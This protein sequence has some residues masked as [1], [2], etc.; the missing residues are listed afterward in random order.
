MFNTLSLRLKFK[1]RSRENLPI[2]HKTHMQNANLLK[3]FKKGA[4]IKHMW[5]TNSES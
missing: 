3:K 5:E 4:K 2:G 1:L